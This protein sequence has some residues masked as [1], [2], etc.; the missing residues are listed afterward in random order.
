[1]ECTH[2]V[3]I[4]FEIQ[5]EEFRLCRNESKNS[6]SPVETKNCLPTLDVGRIEKTSPEAAF[7]AILDEVLRFSAISEEDIARVSHCSAQLCSGSRVRNKSQR[8]FNKEASV[9]FEL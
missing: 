5:E 8:N 1:M 4:K 7:C 9:E 6:S 3:R 2:F